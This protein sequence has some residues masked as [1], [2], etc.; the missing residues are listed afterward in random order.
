MYEAL[1]A[2]E[3]Y[4]TEMKKAAEANGKEIVKLM[5]KKCTDA[6]NSRGLTSPV[7]GKTEPA[8]QREVIEQVRLFLAVRYPRLDNPKN[9]RLPYSR[10]TKMPE[11]FR[12]T[13]VDGDS[14]VFEHEAVETAEGDL[15]ATAKEDC[16]QAVAFIRE[17]A[18]FNE[19]VK[20]VEPRARIIS[21]S[22]SR[23]Q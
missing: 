18:A 13:E 7:Q 23:E 14:N 4:L 22:L 21:R 10:P 16:V 11:N 9:T 6:N 1:A 5:I 2:N 17:K 20:T 15:K 12:P 19:D 3:A 8:I